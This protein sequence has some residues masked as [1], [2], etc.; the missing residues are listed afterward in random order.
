MVEEQIKKTAVSV[1]RLYLVFWA[2][3]VLLVVISEMGGD[4]VGCYAGHVRAAYWAETM[5]IL[6]AAVCVPASLRLF[7]WMLNRQVDSAPLPQA[8]R[9]YVRWSA[10]RL[11]LLECPVMVGFFTYYMMMSSQGLLCALIGLT[12][13]LFCLPGEQRLRRELQ[14]D[15]E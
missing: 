15:H 10:V 6:L 11:A 8:L 2:L 7:A 9:L 5:S 13:S 4:W 14:L 3:P 12:A 1:K